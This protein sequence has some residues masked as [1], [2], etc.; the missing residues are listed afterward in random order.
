MD[1]ADAYFSILYF[2]LCG[3]L[4]FEGFEAVVMLGSC[5]YD[6]EGLN[7]MF[8]ESLPTNGKRNRQHPIDL[9]Q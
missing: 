9:L 4:D 7:T 6:S 3:C 8:G 2:S 1:V 5:G